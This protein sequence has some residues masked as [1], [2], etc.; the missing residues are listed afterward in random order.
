MEMTWARR[1]GR[2]RAR[3]ALLLH[4]VAYLGGHS[5]TMSGV[6]RKK[7]GAVDAATGALTS[8]NPGFNSTFGI[9]AMLAVDSR[10]WAGGDFT[11]VGT[12]R[13]LRLTRFFPTT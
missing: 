5:T 12:T 2:R 4:A 13:Q 9:C 10:L 1:S 3:A 8:W 6:G 11:K 7:G